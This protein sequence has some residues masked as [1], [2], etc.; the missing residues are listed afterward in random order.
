MEPKN[1]E[2]V[3]RRTVFYIEGF[4]PRGPSHY[5]S[6]YRD[7]AATVTVKSFTVYE[8]NFIGWRGLVKP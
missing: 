1:G 2:P 7:E 6:I 5:Y 8:Q 3:S 4:D